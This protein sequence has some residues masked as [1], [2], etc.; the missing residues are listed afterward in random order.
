MLL[1]WKLAKRLVIAKT[2]GFTIW[3]IAFTVFPM[4]FWEWET[5]LRLA[6]LLWYTTLWG[7]IGMVWFMDR[8]PIYTKIRFN[9]FFRG[10]FFGGWMN[11]LLVLFVYERFISL[12]AWTFLEFTSPFILVFPW[13]IAW[14]IVD[15]FAT[16]FGW[17]GK[18][19]LK[20]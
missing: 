14:L 3:L 12:S 7:I 9:Y 18:K 11:F 13:M 2:I 20:K 19:L 5:T 8:H 6:I 15:Y 16:E 4:V 10:I 17:E 1:K